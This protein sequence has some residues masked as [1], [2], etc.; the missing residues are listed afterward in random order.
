MADELMLLEMEEPMSYSDAA[1]EKEWQTAMNTE[2]DTIEKNKTWTLTN[3]PPGQKAIGL[4]WV[5]KLKRDPEGNI[6]KYK[7]RLVAKGYVQ[8]KGVDYEEVFAP[9]AHLE[10]VRL[11]LGLSAKEGWE[12]HHLDI[13]AAFLNG[14]LVEELYVVEPEGFM[15]NGQEQKVYKL[16]KALYGLRQ[17]P[18]A[19]NAKLD[20]C[21]KEFG[22]KKCLHEQAVYTKCKTGSMLIIGVYV[23]DLLVTGSDKGE[24]EKF[25][26]QMSKQ[27][28]MSDLGLLSYY[29]GIEVNQR[30]GSTTLKQSAYAKK[31]LEKAGMLNCNSSKYPMEQK[32]QLDKDEGGQMINATEYR[33]IVGIL[34]YLTHTRPDIS[35]AVGVV[36]RFMERPT[37][38]HQQAVEH[39]LRYVKGTLD[40]GLVYKKEGSNRVLFGFSDSDLA[41]DVVDRRSTGGICFY[42][43]GSLISW[44]S[45]KQRVI[46]L[47]SC[48]AEY[49]VATTAACQSIWL[50]GLLSEISGQQI[51]PVI[52]YVDNRSAIELIKNHV[53]HGK[54]KHI[55][56]HFHFIRECIER[57]E[58]VVKH[59][60]SQDQ[61]ADIL[62]KA[63]GRV[64]FEAMRKLVGVED[65]AVTYQK[66]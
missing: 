56:V 42:L 35:Y 60:V 33:C 39:I 52:L 22:F 65:L 23:D 34:R 32:L 12:V 3:L 16:L 7:A 11:L 10:T 4:K 59:V 21:L 20:K 6:V 62:T 17:A 2:M 63:L 31:V 8:K 61:R 45:Q 27:F 55:D 36:S 57:G 29:L 14:D 49:M 54:S 28:E 13:K 18:R 37:I 24:I 50:R 26:M 51:G 53:L 19:W 41:G 43:N 1:E 44:V 30:E 25:K 46:A 64:K 38:Q 47:S 66:A 15:K 58:L 5:Y 40:F 9:V 48:E